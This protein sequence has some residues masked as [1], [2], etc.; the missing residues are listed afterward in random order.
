MSISE[1]RGMRVI[2]STHKSVISCRISK[3]YSYFFS[4][5]SL[6]LRRIL[7]TPLTS[8]KEV[9]TTLRRVG[10]SVI[11][12]EHFYKFLEYC[13][14]L[15]LNLFANFYDFIVPVSRLVLGFLCIMHRFSRTGNLGESDDIRLGKLCNASEAKRE[16]ARK[17]LTQA[18]FSYQKAEEMCGASLK[19]SWRSLGTQIPHR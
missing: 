6:R 10:T 9:W 8:P 4:G 7:A 11:W 16:V 14:E 2:A 18:C 19:S 1:F 5:W 3:K 17:A 13:Q 15:C 12:S